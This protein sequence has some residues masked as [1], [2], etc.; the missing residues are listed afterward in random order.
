MAAKQE[1]KTLR[2]DFGFDFI[3]LDG[4]VKKEVNI[5][6]AVAGG[7]ASIKSDIDPLTAY[8]WALKIKKEGF[9]VFSS[10]AEFDK[11]KT[12]I[13]KEWTNAAPYLKGFILTEL[14][15]QNS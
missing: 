8:E 4:E 9:I 14:K 1:I 15:K 6:D 11:I 5:K 7:L 2:A 10:S 12:F 3:D 13:E